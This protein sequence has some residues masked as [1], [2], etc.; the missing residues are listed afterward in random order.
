MAAKRFI[1]ILLN[2]K[3]IMLLAGY[4]TVS[5]ATGAGH[6]GRQYQYR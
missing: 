4:P 6:H 5:Q 3:E 1:P 2:A